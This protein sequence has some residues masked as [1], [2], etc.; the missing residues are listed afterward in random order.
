M[1]LR[2]RLAEAP[3]LLLALILAVTFGGLWWI[4][5]VAIG[6]QPIGWVSVIGAAVAGAVFGVSMT[7]YIV[8]QRKR[9]GGPH[10][11]AALNRALKTGKL[12]PDADRRTWESLVD[13]RAKQQVFWGRV[14]PFEF[15]LFA[16][17]GLYLALTDARGAW[18][19]WLEA[20]GM[21]AFAVFSPISSRR[22]VTKL[23]ELR[24]QL[25]ARETGRSTP[26]A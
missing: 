22:Q 4:L 23:K 2:D 14:G 18:F 24:R 5:I 21:A 12:P 6:L 17:L 15:G 11:L 26:P 8:R 10:N 7:L 3:P 13:H 9:T 16:V 25:D 1:K 19:W 20:V